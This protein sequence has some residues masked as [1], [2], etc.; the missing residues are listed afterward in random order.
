MRKLLSTGIV[1]LG[2]AGAPGGEVRNV[3]V[4]E[5]AKGQCTY[6]PRLST[7]KQ[8]FRE[9]GSPAEVYCHDF[10]RASDQNNMD[11]RLLP[12]IAFVESGGG[13][14]PCGNNWFGWDN[15]RTDFTSVP[16]GI[17][18]VADRLSN[19]TLY[20]EKD[21]DQVLRIYNPNGDYPQ[22]VRS[23]MR[24]ISATTTHPLRVN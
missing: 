6:D 1:F 21:L 22:L 2:I 9:M 17:R 7:L 16:H 18:L 5:D 11:W 24:R 19:S 12:S 13:K 20:K 3:G 8:F 15:G 4:S 14:Q 10:I 23:V